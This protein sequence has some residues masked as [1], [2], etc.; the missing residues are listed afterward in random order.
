M[1]ATPVRIF[2]VFFFFIFYHYHSTWI[3]FFGGPIC[4]AI[5]RF[6]DFPRPLERK[7]PYDSP[8]KSSC[9]TRA[10]LDTE[11]DAGQVWLGL[12]I[13]LGLQSYKI[14][15][16]LSGTRKT[17]GNSEAVL[18]VLKRAA[19]PTQRTSAHALVC[20]PR[21]NPPCRRVFLAVLLT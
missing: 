21:E 7:H 3:R 15:Q 20:K 1:R 13:R 12:E 17:S 11:L 8:P 10:R 5:F 9:L 2:L 16:P 14:R 4:S 19:F 6:P 18:S